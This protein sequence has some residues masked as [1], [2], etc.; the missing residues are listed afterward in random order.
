M[1]QWRMWFVCGTMVAALA[2][3]QPVD[4]QRINRYSNT[5]RGGVE[6]KQVPGRKIGSVTTQ[7][8]VIVLELD[9]GVI[10]DHNLFDLDKRTLRFTPAAGGFRVENLAL[11]WDTAKGTAIQGN[12]VRLTKFSFP[13]SGKSWDS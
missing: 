13:F 10:A 11:H 7:G 12:T 5:E 1:K 3:A 9:S 4:A 6:V 2:A 8:N